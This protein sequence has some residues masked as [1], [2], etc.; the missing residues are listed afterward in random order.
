MS[1][2][3]FFVCFTS[4]SAPVSPINYLLPLASPFCTSSVLWFFLL[5]CVSLTSSNLH[6]PMPILFPQLWTA[7]LIYPCEMVAPPATCPHLLT[8]LHFPALPTSRIS[9]VAQCLTK[10][11]TGIDSASFREKGEH[12]WVSDLWEQ[13]EEITPSSSCA[14]SACPS[15]SDSTFPS[16]PSPP[17]GA[18]DD[19]KSSCLV[20]SLGYPTLLRPRLFLWVLTLTVPCLFTSPRLGSGDTRKDTHTLLDAVSSFLSSHHYPLNMMAELWLPYLSS[21][22]SGTAPGTEGNPVA[23]SNEGD[24]AAAPVSSARKRVKLLSAA[25]HA[26]IRQGLGHDTGSMRAHIEVVMDWLEAVGRGGGLERRGDL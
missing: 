17:S 7:Y 12:H 10:V 6:P 2:A 23:A 9:L 11:C 25:R 15:A 14:P 24:T 16:T 4:V 1:T 26:P 3:L 22:L 19:M 18:R 20:P 21:A 8:R 13:L 5:Y